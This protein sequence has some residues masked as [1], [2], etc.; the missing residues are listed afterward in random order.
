MLSIEQTLSSEKESAK[1]EAECWASE[2]MSYHV[3]ADDAKNY[4]LGLKGMA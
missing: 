2:A 1:R 4:A 3:Q